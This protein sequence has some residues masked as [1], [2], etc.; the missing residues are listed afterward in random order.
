VE[1]V[2][3]RAREL[4]R[5][6]ENVPQLFTA[7]WGLRL[8]YVVRGEL[9]TARELGEQLLILAQR[10]QDP[11]LLVGAHQGIGTV[12]FDSGEFLP[13]QAHLQQGIRLSGQP[14]RLHSSL[15][16][17]DPSVVATPLRR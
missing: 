12:L 9:H 10:V 13:A 6:V 1:Q 8:F 17:R 5:Q 15:Y 4:C 7:I 11:R 14:Q 3:A 16:I 2:Y